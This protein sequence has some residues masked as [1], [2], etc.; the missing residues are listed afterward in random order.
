M[1]LHSSLIATI[2]PKQPKAMTIAPKM[3]ADSLI[4]FIGTTM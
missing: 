2:A 4:A 3:S 1:V